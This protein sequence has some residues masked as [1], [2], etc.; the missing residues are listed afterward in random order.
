MR[1]VWVIVLFSLPLPAGELQV[2]TSRANTV[3]FTSRAPLESF[4]GITRYID[5]YIYWPGDDITR[6][7]ELY[8]EVDLNTIDTGIGMRNRHMRDNYLETDKYPFTHFTGKITRVEDS[9]D[10]IGFVFAEGEL[11]IH[12]V[13]RFL[14]VRARIDKAPGLWHV[15]CD[16]PFRLSDYDI[17]IPKVMFLK[18]NNTMRMNLDFYLK[19]VG[20]D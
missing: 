14:R 19:K 12:G 18:I 15:H 17:D 1:I 4:E 20:D 3:R 13:A 10:T 5:G 11:F 16:F 8:F 2:D 7:S 9:T 6:H